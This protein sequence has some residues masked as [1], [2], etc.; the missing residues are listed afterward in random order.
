MITTG[1]YL[2]PGLYVSFGYSLFNNSNEVKLRYTLSPRW[3]VESNFGTE[4]GADL[5]YKIDIP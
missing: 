1:K 5:F 4:S 2:R 3:E